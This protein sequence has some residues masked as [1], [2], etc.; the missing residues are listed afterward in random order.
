MKL[1][2]SDEKA[3]TTLTEVA[4]FESSASLH[5]CSS[6]IGKRQNFLSMFSFV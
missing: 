1:K 5:N 6:V 2:Y 4:H 3:E